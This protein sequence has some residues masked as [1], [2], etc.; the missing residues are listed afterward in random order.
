AIAW[1]QSNSFHAPGGAAHRTHVQF[2]ET[3][4]H[5]LARDEHD[6]VTRIFHVVIFNN[7]PAREFHLNQPVA[8]LD[9][10]GNDAAL[11]NV[12]EFVERSLLDRALLGG[13]EQFAPLLPGYIL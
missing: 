9:A 6:I 2:A 8:R 7:R 11:S 1:F 10:D 13:K 5:A 3:D 4:A 12:G